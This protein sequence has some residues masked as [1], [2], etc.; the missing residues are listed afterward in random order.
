[1]NLLEVLW[2]EWYRL[3]RD[4]YL[5]MVMAILGT[6]EILYLIL[7]LTHGHVHGART[8]Q[9]FALGV[10]FALEYPAVFIHL[11]ISAGFCSR[12]T[13][14]KVIENRNILQQRLCLRSLWSRV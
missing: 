8:W 13:D 12:S 2:I 10:D 3:W 6:Q 7:K 9:A 14:L 1:M 11:P 5:G 4:D